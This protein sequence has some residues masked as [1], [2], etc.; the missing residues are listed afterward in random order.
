MKYPTSVTSTTIP[1]VLKENTVDFIDYV[2]W[3][4]H[5]LSKLIILI[6]IE[7]NVK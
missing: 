7:L 6:N 2:I 5:V 1:A 3:V 4:V